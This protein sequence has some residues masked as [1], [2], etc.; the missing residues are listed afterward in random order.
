MRLAEAA[1]SGFDRQMFAAALGAL[2]QIS[3]TAFA[4]YGVEQAA[5]GVMRER[6]S[7]WRGELLGAVG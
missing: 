2:Q 5:A 4:A 6:F 1:D 3:D 7:E